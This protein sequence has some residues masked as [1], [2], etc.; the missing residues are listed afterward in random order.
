ML[1]G[2]SKFCLLVL[3]NKSLKREKE[4]DHSKSRVA[5]NRGAVNRGLTVILLISWGGINPKNHIKSK[6][7][8]W[9]VKIIILIY[10]VITP[11][12][13]TCIHLTN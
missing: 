11:N 12:I 10:V 9:K 7:E 8:R 1:C 3:T 5:V 4:N 6:K 2:K 13:P